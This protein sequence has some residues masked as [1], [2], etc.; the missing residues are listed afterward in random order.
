MQ[1]VWHSR[2]RWRNGFG[3]SEICPNSGTC[4]KSLAKPSAPIIC[5]KC[6]YYTIAKTP[7]IRRFH[8]LYICVVYSVCAL[9][10]HKWFWRKPS[11]KANTLHPR[12]ASTPSPQMY[13]IKHKADETWAI[14]GGGPSYHVRNTQITMLYIY[15]ETSSQISFCTISCTWQTESDQRALCHIRWT[16][17]SLLGRIMYVQSLTLECRNEFEPNSV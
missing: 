2:M 15:I 14:Y 13:T 8:I 3:L 16:F 17:V 10:A 5:N 6:Q 1:S 11:I 9:F 12:N 7:G 4:S